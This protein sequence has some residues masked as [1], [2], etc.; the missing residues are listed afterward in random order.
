MFLICL[1]V[2]CILGAS[3]AN[4]VNLSSNNFDK[5]VDGSTNA[6]VEFFAPWCGHCKSL[7]PEW[8]IA[9][10]TFQPSDDIII[11][12]VDAT[13]SPA[14]AEKYQVQGYPTIKFFAKGSSD[15]TP[16]NYEG[17]R[18]ASD[19][20]KWVNGKI[21]TSR[22]VKVAPTAVTVLTSDNFDDLVLGSKAALVEFYAPW[23]GH[24][25]SLAPEYEIT[26]KAFAGEKDVVIGKVDATEENDLAKKYGV[27]GYPTLKFFPAGSSE[28]IDYNSARSAEAMVEFINKNA[29]TSRNVDGSLAALAGRI[30]D[31]DAVISSS[32]V[33]DNAFLATLTETAN[34]LTESPY[35][36][37][38]L[39]S[40]AKI[41]SKGNEY[42][43]KEVKR[44]DGMMQS[45][46]VTEESK[47]SFK[48]RQNILKAF[49]K[50]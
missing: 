37:N 22:R 46:S 10:E 28:P 1:T 17:G 30:A 16:E 12:A 4:V 8:A 20:V 34:A 38:Y 19:I 25:K 23:C 40:A 41:V 7:A 35:T 42:I 15:A 36:K 29:G 31:L 24:C 50:E 33:Y 9:G 47:T 48:I 5:I 11:A 39:S 45:P 14:L 18:T 21:G 13:E 43:G 6:L 44:L 26:G 27:S 2:L 32:S 3:F 49:I